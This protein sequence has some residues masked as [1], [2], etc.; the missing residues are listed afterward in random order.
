MPISLLITH[1][2]FI[3]VWFNIVA[4]LSMYP[5]LMREGLSLPT[6]TLCGLFVVMALF[7]ADKKR[8]KLIFTEMFIVSLLAITY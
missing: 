4:V 1:H 2:L 8:A 3:V 5:L 6:W 7:I